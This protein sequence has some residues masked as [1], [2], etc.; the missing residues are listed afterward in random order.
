V[1]FAQ[2][3]IR[4]LTPA[5]VGNSG[6]G[7]LSP[8]AAG[9]V[10]TAWA[11]KDCA[12]ASEKQARDCQGGI[13]VVG[14]MGFR[15]E[16]CFDLNGYYG[17]RPDALA[18]ARGRAAAVEFIEDIVLDFRRTTGTGCLAEAPLAGRKWRQTLESFGLCENWTVE[19]SLSPNGTSPEGTKE[20]QTVQL[21]FRS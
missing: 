17:G 12:L 13:E 10:Y 21:V 9:E 19:L 15:G 2:T 18:A 6:A 8:Q 1:R 14:K 16:V 7:C 20:N 3:Y 4:P 5:P 11:E